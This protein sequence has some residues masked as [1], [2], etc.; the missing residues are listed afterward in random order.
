MSKEYY[1]SKFT[2]IFKAVY[3]SVFFFIAF[4]F[5]FMALIYLSVH[6]ASVVFDFPMTYGDDWLKWRRTYYIA[7][8]LSW[9]IMINEY[10]EGNLTIVK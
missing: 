9:I 8:I 7:G 10:I 2:V 1:N 6:L 4:M 5:T 3:F